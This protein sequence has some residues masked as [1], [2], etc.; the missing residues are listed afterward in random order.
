MTDIKTR[1]A[2]PQSSGRLERLHRTH[3]EEGLTE[4]ALEAM[5]DGNV[6]LQYAATLLSSW[7]L[8]GASIASVRGTRGIT[9]ARSEV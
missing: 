8:M 1:A 6:A 2:H 7:H 3:R 4:E 9:R 5:T